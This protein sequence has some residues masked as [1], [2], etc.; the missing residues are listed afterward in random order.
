MCASCHPVLLPDLQTALQRGCIVGIGI[1]VYNSWM[2]SPVVRVYGN[3]TAPLPGEVPQSTGHAVALVGY[4][5]DPEF[6][7]GG[8][9]IVRN[10]WGNAW[11]SQGVF[12]P[13]YGTI[14]YRYIT[15]FNSDA[16]CIV[17]CPHPA[18]KLPGNGVRAASYLVMRCAAATTLACVMFVP[19]ARK[20]TAAISSNVPTQVL[21]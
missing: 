18:L 17:A 15:G 9:F 1:P 14:P 16:W 7:D 5:D 19:K 11:T 3:I 2:N 20:K 8:Y 4:A 10:S 6:A 21:S 13:G 12:G